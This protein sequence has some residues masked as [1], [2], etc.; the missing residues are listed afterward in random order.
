[1]KDGSRKMEA[2]HE[3]QGVICRVERVLI[4][5]SESGNSSTQILA[6]F[7]RPKCVYSLTETRTAM[8][9][10]VRVFVDQGVE[11]MQNCACA[12]APNMQV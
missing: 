2:N 10:R 6:C 9:Q 12:C 1:M 7:V 4:V 11:G 8:T 3:L 5:G